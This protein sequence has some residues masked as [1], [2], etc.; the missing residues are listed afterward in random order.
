MVRL[1]SVTA[2]AS[3]LR[4][5]LTRCLADG[6]I[7]ASRSRFL[8]QSLVYGC[9]E[10][11]RKIYVLE[12]GWVKTVMMS[13]GGKDCLLGLY[14]PGDVFGELALVTDQR[15]ESAVAMAE[16]VIRPVT[17]QAMSTADLPDGL[18]ATLLE[19]A[20]TKMAEQQV[21]IC[22]LV[23]SQSEQR[24][25]ST[26]LRL[27][28]KFGARVGQFLRLDANLVTQQELSEM[29]GTTRSRVGFFLRCFTERGILKRVN[30]YLVLH[31]A[32]FESY[33]TLRA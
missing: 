16:C 23:T 24:V 2:D 6:V 4:E 18:L 33:L 10:V 28:K 20:L 8:K 25:A 15:H 32:Q 22:D 31:E 17:R 5:E 19:Y 3:P 26:L 7:T 30:G 12:K 21:T 11:D 29:V 14:G 9:G 13:P 27:A 1:L